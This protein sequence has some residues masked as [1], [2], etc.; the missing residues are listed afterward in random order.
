M[1]LFKGAF[2]TLSLRVVSLGAGCC[3]NSRIT[4]VNPRV[5]L[6]LQPLSHYLFYSSLTPRHALKLQCPRRDS[7]F[8]EDFG[9]HE[10]LCDTDRGYTRR[11]P[12]DE[13]L[14][15]PRDSGSQASKYHCLFPSITSHYNRKYRILSRLARYYCFSP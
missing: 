15:A 2:V 7:H 4:P 8:W 5:T 1:C 3:Y 11:T 6:L 9:L 14:M 12:Y 10:Y 13:T